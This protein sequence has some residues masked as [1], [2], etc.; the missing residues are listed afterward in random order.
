MMFVDLNR[1]ESTKG[2]ISVGQLE[3]LARCAW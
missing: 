1:T 2:I 3:K